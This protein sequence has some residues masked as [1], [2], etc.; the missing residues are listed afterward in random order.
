LRNNTTRMGDTRTAA[1]FMSQ[2]VSGLL[3][4]EAGDFVEL[5][6]F[7]DSGGALELVSTAPLKF[8]MVKVAPAP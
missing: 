2:S 7:Q 3:L 5:S 4:L 6:V 8:E 1:G